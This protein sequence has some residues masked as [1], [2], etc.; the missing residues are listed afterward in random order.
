MKLKE[1]KQAATYKVPEAAAVA[2]VGDM[3][4]RNGIKAGT[5]PH[6]KFGRNILIPKAAFHRFLDSCGGQ[7]A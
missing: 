6:I 2:G 1:N 4:I 5:I 7:T 3:A